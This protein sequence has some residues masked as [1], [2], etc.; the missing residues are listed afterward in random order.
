MFGPAKCS[1]CC[2]PMLVSDAI[3]LLKAYFH[4]LILESVA[5]LCWENVG[6]DV[7]QPCHSCITVHGLTLYRPK[8]NT[9]SL[10]TFVGMKTGLY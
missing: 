1:H 2:Q 10:L 4:A 8:Y 5:D 6:E 9:G 3:K 7:I